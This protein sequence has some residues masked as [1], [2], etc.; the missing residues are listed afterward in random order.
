MAAAST[1]KNATAAPKA[2]DSARKVMAKN[3]K[4][5]AEKKAK[6]EKKAKSDLKKKIETREKAARK[7]QKKAEKLSK[8][9]SL[10]KNNG[11]IHFESAMQRDEA[12]AYFEA[13][14]GGLKKGTIQFKSDKDTVIV[15]PPE[16][17]GVEVRAGTKGKTEHVTF[18]LSWK[19]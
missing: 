16:N 19:R 5:E 17:V 15:R 14:I 2:N 7:S 6:M 4:S 1:L 9:K 12:V 11:K 3:A 13:I 18:N 10:K 8:K